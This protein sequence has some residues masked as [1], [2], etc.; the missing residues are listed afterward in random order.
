MR[1]DYKSSLRQDSFTVSIPDSWYIYKAHHINNYLPKLNKDKRAT[2]LF[3]LARVNKDFNDR[4]I[5]DYVKYDLKKTES[6]WES[7]SQ[8]ITVS[9]SKYGEKITVNGDYLYNGQEM[10][11]VTSYY[12]VNNI[13]YKI[14]YA[15]NPSL[16][17]KYINEV[18]N[19]IESF[20]VK[21]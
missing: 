18:M 12:K 6:H 3:F 7:I 4:S 5:L 10:I 11:F 13:F 14:K 1:N 19:I 21:E 20:K 8:L 15:S 16:F 2:Y 17:G 9:K